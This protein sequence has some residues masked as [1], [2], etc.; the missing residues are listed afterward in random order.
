MLTWVVCVH[1][2]LI[3][4][5]ESLIKEIEVYAQE[6]TYKCSLS[7]PMFTFG[8]LLQPN[9]VLLKWS[10]CVLAVLSLERDVQ[11]QCP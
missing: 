1:T 11:W 4:I 5:Q 3:A 7:Y 2:A 6:D 10:T 9:Y 8:L